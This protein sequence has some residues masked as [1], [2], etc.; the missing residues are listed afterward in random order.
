ML[1]AIKLRYIRPSEDIQA[2]LDAHKAWL[3]KYTQAG[4]I[5]FA[6][7]APQ[8][9][10]GFVLAHA[11]DLAVIQSMIAEDPFDIHQLVTF[12]IDACDPALRATDFPARW[13]GSAKPI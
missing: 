1:F 13:A 11:D 7:P 10:A 6:G 5:L 3:I 9:N 2:H 4:I 12:E 8:G